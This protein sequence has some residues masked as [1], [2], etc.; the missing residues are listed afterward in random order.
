M[1][2]IRTCF[3]WLWERRSTCRKLSLVSSLPKMNF[4]NLPQRVQQFQ[5][6]SVWLEFSPLSSLCNAIN[7]GQGFPDWKPPNFVLEAASKASS[8]PSL[9]QYARSS[10]LQSLVS[11]ISKTYAP[12][13]QRSIDPNKEVCITVGASEAIF[14]ACQTFVEPGDEVIFIEPAFDIY[15]GAV[16]Y[17]GATPRFV[18]LLMQS[19]EATQPLAASD[20]RL[21]YEEL[22]RVLSERS[23]LL[24][25]NTPHNPT[26]KVFKKEE[27]ENIAKVLQEFPR[28]LVLCDEVYQHLVYDDEVHVPMA[29]IENMWERT[30]SVYSAGKTFSVT[31]WKIGWAIGP[32]HLIRPMMLSQQWIVFSTT[33]PLQ[34]AVASSLEQATQPFESEPTYYAWLR[35]RYQRKRDYFYQ[36]LIE[37]GLHPVKP[38]GSFFIMIDISEIQGIRNE[39]PSIVKEWRKQGLL[40]IDERT[41]NAMDYNFCRWQAVEKGVTAIPCSAFYSRQHQH[42]GS[43]YVR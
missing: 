43:R 8:D 7:L 22:R 27:L 21:D 37:A 29:T 31:G 17:A 16:V 1:Q 3:L 4:Y 39:M 25:L 32:F 24:I 13:L 36:A 42:L 14:L 5:E 6:P 34:Q 40:D 9:S 23:R 11:T 35:K 20:L 38:Q 33:T 28:C 19:K 2:V 10:G 30:I 41:Q 15:F 26:G 12:L 18:S